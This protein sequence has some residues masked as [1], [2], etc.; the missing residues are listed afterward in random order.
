MYTF[1]LLQVPEGV[2]SITRSLVLV[3][4]ENGV[5]FRIDLIQ[6]YDGGIIWAVTAQ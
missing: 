3:F 6:L 4:E 5:G 1:S 2:R